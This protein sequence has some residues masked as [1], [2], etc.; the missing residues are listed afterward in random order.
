VT[1]RS[2]LLSVALGAFWL[3]C[4]PSSRAQAQTR[5][6]RLIVNVADQT[7]AVLPGATVT[8][9]AEDGKALPDAMTGADG[10]ATVTGIAT[11]RYR[12]TVQFPGFETGRIADVRV[13]AGDNRQ[14][15]VLQLEKLQDEVTV[16]QDKRSAA[17]DPRGPTFG[18]AL[19]REQ[20]DAL[21]D[22]PEE[23]KR[24][25]QD[26]VGGNAVVRV[27]S[28][29]GAQLPPK[30]QIRSI[31]VS[32]DAFAA[33][34]H[35]A[36]G[37]YV[38]I[39]TQPGGGPVRGG[40]QYRLRDG[41]LSGRSPLT[42]TKGPERTQDYQTTLSGTLVKNKVGFSV[43]FNG[44]SQFTTPLLNAALTSGT[45][46]EALSVRTPTTYT[47]GSGSLDWAVTRDQIIRLGYAQN[48]NSTNNLGIGLY[49]LPERAYSTNSRLHQFRVQ[50]VGPLG[51]R[52]FMN[53]R[54]YV[55]RQESRSRSALEAPTIRVQDAFTSGGQQQSGGRT[56]TDVNQSSDIDYVRGV[57]SV[58]FGHVTDLTRY[59]S[60]AFS[61]YLGTY[62]FASLEDYEA[63]KPLSYTRRIGN[64]QIEYVNV[65]TG[66]YLQDDIRVR[67]GLTLS[68]GVRYEAQ[69]HLSDYN[70]F[71]PRFGVT[72]APLK[73]GKTTLR[74]SAGIFYDWLSTGTYEQTLRVDGVRQRE[75]NIP[76]PSYPDP[77]TEG[78]VP[79][80]NKYLL[81]NGLRAPR[82]VRFSG[83]IDQAVT[84]L[85][86]V[87]VTYSHM[88]GSNL[89]RGN[90]LNAAVDGV[91][92]DP[93]FINIVE[94][95][96]DARSRQDTI[97]F[98]FDGGLAQV[99]PIVG[100]S[101]P[102]LDWRRTRFFL[103]YTL[104][105]QRNDTD[106]DFSLAPGPQ[107]EEWAYANFDVRHRGSAGINT[108]VLRGWTTT[109][110]LNASSGQ[111]YT[112]RTGT[113][114]NGDLVF[115]DRPAGVPRN[116][117]R[118]PGQWTLSMSSSYSIPFG[119]R[120]TPPP[121]GIAI[122]I[123]GNSAPTI[124]TVNIDWR[125]R[126]TVFVQ[127]QNLTNRA[128]YIGYSGVMNSRF[129][130]KPTS[131]ASTRKI[132]MGITLSF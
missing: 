44:T 132:D 113:D 111:P 64:P 119:R 41:S 52:L 40:V 58:R 110:N 60:N 27:D 91:L 55:V 78:F 117:E 127:A 81:G 4:V 80:V 49:D 15:V 8:V 10:T 104:G 126:L 120:A 118:Q 70:N 87:S 92:P 34:F 90:N 24:Q 108:Q 45:R 18:S 16:E 88:T 122:S 38:D 106:G 121:P 53:H 56:L 11:G 57:H 101:A 75:I 115:N 46:S 112:V 29:E 94:V 96:A 129:F 22:D 72:W 37:I 114:D 17:A 63:G 124:Q 1:L 109:L 30:S 103:N 125:Y 82:T 51:R 67:P 84:R 73:S 33:E 83:G 77:G 28:F 42:P 99:P 97:S 89:F 2:L 85:D 62:T 50:E 32:R 7:G 20:I 6:A 47:N 74:A 26:L 100:K 3:M 79:P 23:A 25:L 36:G 86:R 59:D 13:R 21:S 12:V 107:A 128:N 9:T 66:L 19:T 35:Q 98:N 39:V 14:N 93:D 130:G 68:P 95:V 43:S 105:W 71:G 102:L 31:R 5:P 65:T 131:V 123:S 54:L 61:N 48:E 69:T 116:T 76:D